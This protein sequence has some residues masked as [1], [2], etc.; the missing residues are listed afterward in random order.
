MSYLSPSRGRGGTEGVAP[1]VPLGRSGWNF[2]QVDELSTE[3]SQSSIQEWARR[4]IESSL[5]VPKL[6]IAAA[7]G[8]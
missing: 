6:D 2:I 5:T 1:P 4:R 7:G 3:E 8:G